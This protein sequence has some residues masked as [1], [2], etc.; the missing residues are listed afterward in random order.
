MTLHSVSSV[1]NKSGQRMWHVTITV[2]GDPEPA[3]VVREALERLNLDHPFLLE[4]RYSSDHAEIRYWEEA[5]D[6]NTAAQ[7]A[8]E[9]WHNNTI[10]AHL[11]DWDVVGLHVLDRASYL[12]RE[13]LRAVPAGQ[14]LPFG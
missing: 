4:A 3:D 12:K 2:C 8:S 9:M 7:A 10:T 6:M 1:A 5:Q 11:P 13:P 14:I